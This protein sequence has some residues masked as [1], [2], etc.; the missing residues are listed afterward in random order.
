MS[1]AGELIARIRLDGTDAFIADLDRAQARAE[2]LGTADPK[3]RVTTEGAGKAVAELEAVKVAEDKVESGTRRIAAA[4]KDGAKQAVDWRGALV[5]SLVAVSAAAPPVA[6]G[7]LAIGGAF[8]VMAGA[9]ILGLA[10]IVRGLKENNAVGQQY[11]STVDS[12]TASFHSAEDA[13]A[14][15]LFPGVQASAAL[16]AR[17]MPAI[18]SEVSHFA[19]LLGGMLPTGLDAT[20]TLLERAN[21]LFD[22]AGGYL[23]SLVTGLD[24]W[25]HSNGYQQFLDYSIRELPQVEHLLG[26]AGHLV[27]DFLKAW[28]PVG[29]ETLPLLDGI[30]T[31]VDDIVKSTGPIVPAVIAGVGAFNLLKPVVG[32]IASVTAA[33]K[34]MT[35]AEEAAAVAGGKIKVGG[36]G[37]LGKAGGLGSLGIAGITL[38]GAYLAG[39]TAN[40]IAGQLGA[41]PSAGQY[42][43]SQA[44][45]KQ[46]LAG[47]AGATNIWAP[48]AD[49]S[50]T[51]ASG[52]K[53]LA[54][55]PAWMRSIYSSDIGGA[56]GAVG[57][58]FGNVSA[59]K[60]LNSQDSALSSMVNAGQMKQAAAIF[61]RVTKAAKDQG[62]SISTL[63][64][65]YPQYTAAVT[66]AGKANGGTAGSAKG[67]TSALTAQT[68]ITTNLTAAQQAQVLALRAVAEGF[69]SDMT[70][71]ELTGNTY[72]DVTITTGTLIASF[73]QQAKASKDGKVS[74]DEN[75]VAGAQNAQGM[76]T[77][78][79]K[80]KAH[81]D[82]L[83]SDG[84]HAAE[85]RAYTLSHARSLETQATAAGAD[86][87]KVDSLIGSLIGVSRTRP[88][89][90]VDVQTA[91]AMSA[92]EAL[93][94]KLGNLNG[95]TSWVYVN[96]AGTAAGAAGTAGQ[97]ARNAI[98]GYKAD[99]GTIGHAA[100]GVTTGGFTVRGP[101]TA[102]NDQAGLWALANGEEVISDKRGQAAFWRPAL[103]AM[104]AGMP[105]AAVLSKVAKIAG[106][107]GYQG[108]TQVINRT[109]APV[110]H[111]HNPVVQDLETLQRDANQYQ[112]AYAGIG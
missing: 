83:N 44:N 106:H 107:G 82:A 87:G 47:L 51:G 110:I 95:Y 109:I 39:D 34:G 9:G 37:G 88:V 23:G 90:K 108:P 71:A 10:G 21:P 104:N 59:A 84:K 19:G 5:G 62:L 12:L 24:K 70:A 8:G 103:K 53:A 45:G 43:T 41:Q 60:N 111:I 85:A 2:E 80:I 1:E 79:D 97:I 63:K 76:R 20:V 48:S 49:G 94:N 98:Y 68:P 91:Q 78:V 32:T 25:S 72:D 66:A 7:A 29:T 99:G 18:N 100:D 27:I 61:A 31:G 96:L 50:A 46:Y 67:L 54:N 35:V 92:L 3:I 42:A 11:R 14:G 17:D 57:G 93:Q 6:A 77:A 38:A 36:P 112:L 105:P 4:Q 28:A 65:L 86:K 81:A 101:G 15:G 13:A 22:A 16:L 64:G 58:G 75:T 33:L 56:L 102:W 30:V 89:S 52:L 74:L 69:R 26:D 73:Q 40:G 55:M